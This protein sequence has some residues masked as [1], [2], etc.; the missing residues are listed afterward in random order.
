[1]KRIAALCLALML[2]GGL[3][4]LPSLAASAAPTLWLSPTG[5]KTA[6]AICWFKPDGK[7]EYYFFLP[8]N[9]DLSRMQFGMEGIKKLEFPKHKI[10]DGTSAEFLKPGNYA[11]TMDGKKRTLHVLQ[12][13]GGIPAI[14]ITT[15]SGKL[16]KLHESKENKETGYLVFVGPDGQVQY[17][18]E[19]THIKC[20]GNSSMTFLK[21]NYQIKLKEGA[22]L[23]GMGKCRKW[24]LTGNYRDKSLMRNQ[25]VYDTAQYMEMP[26]TPEH[27]SAELYIN[28]EYLGLYLF[29][30]KVMIDDD[31]VD[32][33]DLE[34]EMEEMNDKSLDSYK[35]VGKPKGKGN[36]K[37][38]AIPNEPED[39]SGGYLVEFESY[40]VRYNQE[41][42]AYETKKENVLVVKSPEYATE[43]QMKYVS[44]KL[45]AFENAIFSSDGVDAATGLHYSDIVDFESLVKKYL[46]EEF[47]K[48]YDGNS[49]SMYFYKPDD[50]VS[51]KFFAGPV[52]DYDST[53]GSYAGEH[54]AKNVLSGSQFWISL[55]NS[56]KKFWWP[57][58]YKHAEFQQGVKA[59]WQERFSSAARILLGK[60]KDES[61]CLRSVDEYAALIKA[62]AD[63]DFT[64]WPRP[65]NPSSVAKTGNT[66]EKNITYLKNFIAER[67]E[68]L[69]GEW[70][71]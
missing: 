34:A 24:I 8:A 6:D 43:S 25:I 45:Q 69:Q 38:Y 48:N 31:R 30:E 63:M 68:F 33:R 13:S 32:I 29:S 44:S 7:N 37:A 23:M 5:Q 42:S 49:S 65:A 52:W 67:Y 16:T 61:G 40:P 2:M 54:N 64:R 46:I 28:N 62:S 18:G 66:F 59:M 3:L 35:R 4:P 50:S 19:L 11:V 20:R 60:E 22:S 10:S 17:D 51:D 41:A 9:L 58:L 21:R 36:Y 15:Q 53:F 70:G 57:A 26:Y 56:E 39:I 27:I 55:Q 1:M 71:E 47:S 14:Y 12:G